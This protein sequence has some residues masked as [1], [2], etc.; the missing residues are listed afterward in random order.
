MYYMLISA[1]WINAHFSTHSLARDLFSF[2]F[3]SFFS[4]LL[5]LIV[6]IYS[7]CT[8]A[9]LI[10]LY[11]FIFIIRFFCWSYFLS[12]LSVAIAIE[13]VLLLSASESE[14]KC[15]M[16]YVYLFVC[17]P[18]YLMQIYAFV[19]SAYF[20]FDLVMNRMNTVQNLSLFTHKFSLSIALFSLLF[21]RCMCASCDVAVKCSEKKETKT[22]T[23]YK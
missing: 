4:F 23:E 15:A 3:S 20:S 9:Y 22:T 19:R 6:A 12:S 5:I 7:I 8:F 18:I 21:F 11:L 13:L 16:R 10:F 14:S 17:L 1:E 2:I